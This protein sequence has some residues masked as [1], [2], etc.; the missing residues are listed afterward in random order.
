MRLVF[1]VFK[2]FPFGGMQRNMLAIAEAC[3]QRGHDITVLCSE[4][5]GEIPQDIRVI[6]LPSRGWSNA[7]RMKS[8][9]KHFGG[10]LQHMSFDLVV[11][12]NRFP[13]L[14]AY[15]AADSCFA[16]SAYN[17][18]SW[19]YRV[20]PRAKTYL[21]FE[22]AVF[23]LDSCTKILEVS[24]VERKKFQWHYATQNERFYTLPPGIA[25]NRSAPSNYAEIRE[26]KRREL[27][28]GNDFL[29]ML[30]GS[31][32]K[33]KGLDR[34]I[35]LLANWQ[36]ASAQVVRLI[37]VGNDKQSPYLRLAAKKKV[38]DRI[39]FLGGRDDVGALLQ[40]AD[41]LVHPAY[42]ENTGNVLLEAMIAGK[43]VVATDVCGYAHYVEEAGMGHIIRSPY[44][45]E[46]FR[47]AV[48][49]V[50]TYP[51][52]H[53]YE[54]GKVF[55]QREDI[56]SR[57]QYAANLLES[58]VRQRETV[59]IANNDMTVVLSGIFSTRWA[60]HDAFDRVREVIGETVR[61][62]EG[63]RTVRFTFDDRIYYLKHH[64]GVGWTEITKNYLQLK[65]PV[66]S[67]ENEWIAIN[68]LK[69]LHI[70]TLVPVAFGRRGA[71]PARR[72]SFI[73][74]EELQN[75]ISLAKY[76]EMWPNKPPTFREKTKLIK[77][78]A[79][80]AKT[81]HDNGINHRDLYIC[82]FLL[83][84]PFVPGDEEPQLYLVDLHRAQ[85]RNRVPRRWL[86]KDIASIYFSA[87]DIGLRRR[88]VYRFLQHYFDLPLSTILRD[89]AAFLSAVRKRANQLYLRD[90]NTPAPEIV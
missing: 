61:E 78:V 19:L 18:H 90:F 58:F 62:K 27:S 33:T 43:P 87:M 77:A 3:Q 17:G 75:T 73:L 67:A 48:A 71:N 23:S 88:D 60:P 69:T 44:T 76:A 65:K 36:S 83:K 11:G 21:E 68:R 85:C 16:H 56:Y 4:W 46:K 12:F 20:T 25:R 82:H 55:A 15:Y 84:L 1:V 31:G 37:V 45:I 2:Y 66:T 22:Q 14:D 5:H 35:E 6:T 40:A 57:P 80:I 8:F 28:V 32:F 10:E 74:T 24:P 26:R 54:L 41:V 70:N 34:C 79:A 9:A 49:D 38:V 63:R 53:W 64:T 50:M 59:N 51:A 86:V 13:N 81:I 89:H 42:K 39:C 47:K 52:N 29:L 30:L 7:G 72:E